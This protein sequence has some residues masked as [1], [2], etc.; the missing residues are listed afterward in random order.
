LALSHHKREQEHSQVNHSL[1]ALFIQQSIIHSELSDLPQV[2]TLTHNPHPLRNI[3]IAKI[4]PTQLE[5]LKHSEQHLIHPR[6]KV[7]RDESKQT[8]SL[9]QH[10]N[11]KKPQT[12]HHSSQSSEKRPKQQ[13]NAKKNFN[14]STKIKN[15]EM[16]FLV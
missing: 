11:P 5:H 13:K 8:Q 1:K 7:S 3:K 15:Q 14:H 16:L 12:L 6:V 2:Q 4:N 9:V 10:H